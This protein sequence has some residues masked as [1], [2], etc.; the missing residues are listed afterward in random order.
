MNLSAKYHETEPAPSEG[1]TGSF[2]PFPAPFDPKQTQSVAEG[3]T[4][5]DPAAP[6]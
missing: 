3:N 5:A 2:P 6:K 1:A 4:E